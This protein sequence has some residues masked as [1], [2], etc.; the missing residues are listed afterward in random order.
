LNFMRASNVICW[1]FWKFQKLYQP[2]KS[3]LSIYFAK[4]ANLSCCEKVDWK[5]VLK[6]YIWKLHSYVTFWK[7]LGHDLMNQAHAMHF[8][9]IFKNMFWMPNLNNGK[10]IFEGLHIVIIQ[11]FKFQKRCIKVHNGSNIS[12]TSFELFDLENV[13]YQ[14]K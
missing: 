7:G 8:S 6:I 13:Q 11:K 9:I 1:S 3:L 2:F 12:N 10:L 5:W 4:F 14:P